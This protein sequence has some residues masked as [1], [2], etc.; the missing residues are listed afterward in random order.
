MVGHPS[1][2]GS[3][4]SE[5]TTVT[6]IHKESSDQPDALGLIRWP[7]LHLTVSLAQMIDGGRAGGVGGAAGGGFG[8]AGGAPAAG[9]FAVFGGK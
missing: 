3:L 6:E 2:Q 1:Q 5:P 8:G 7:G 9:G 4:I